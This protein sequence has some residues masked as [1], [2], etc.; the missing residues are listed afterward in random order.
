MLPNNKHSCIN[1]QRENPY[2][3]QKEI[4]KKN[5]NIN[6]RTPRREV[7]FYS[8][9]RKPFFC[10][11]NNKLHSNYMPEATEAECNVLKVSLKSLYV[12]WMCL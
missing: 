1:L 11:Y 8:F 12:C 9:S 2:E 6:S 7:Y 5:E 3:N 10:I 4:K